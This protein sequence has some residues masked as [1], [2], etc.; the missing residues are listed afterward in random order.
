M[1]TFCRIYLHH[2]IGQESGSVVNKSSTKI[3]ST[4]FPRGGLLCSREGIKNDFRLISRFV[5]EMI[6]DMAIVTMEDE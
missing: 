2:L 1:H 5:L 3:F 4:V 6:Q